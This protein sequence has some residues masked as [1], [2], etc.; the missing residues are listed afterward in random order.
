MRSGTK[1]KKQNHRAVFPDTVLPKNRKEIILQYVTG[2]DLPKKP[3]AFYLERAERSLRDA[4]FEYDQA[5]FDRWTEDCK[6]TPQIYEA[7]LL[8]SRV[9]S[10]EV[11]HGLVLKILRETTE[12]G[13]PVE[14]FESIPSLI[15][16]ENAI[17][18]EIGALGERIEGHKSDRIAQIGQTKVM[19]VRSMRGGKKE[20]TDARRTLWE[21]KLRRE[22]NTHPDL[23][24]REIARNVLGNP[25][26]P[27]NPRK[28]RGDG[29]LSALRRYVRDI[30]QERRPQRNSPPK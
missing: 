10:L 13:K 23:S 1:R 25:P 24:D 9:K 22:I 27:L 30:R 28:K 21:G 17:A 8:I 26:K 15:D 3:I 4:G 16:H 7:W 11:I 29:S 18:K 14:G 6:L 19:N 2:I 5:S 20:R 12:A